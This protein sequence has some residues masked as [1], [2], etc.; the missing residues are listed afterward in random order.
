M[1]FFKGTGGAVED[2]KKKFDEAT[3][4][5]EAQEVELN[6]YIEVLG[7]T[8]IA[9]KIRILSKYLKHL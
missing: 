9:Q 7:K 3:K 8:N 1:K 2:F 6:N 4:A 5:I